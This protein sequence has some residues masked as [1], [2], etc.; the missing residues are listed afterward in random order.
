MRLELSVFHL[1]Q[2]DPHFRYLQPPLHLPWSPSTNATTTLGKIHQY[3]AAYNTTTPTIMSHPLERPDPIAHMLM[4]MKKRVAD[5]NYVPPPLPSVDDSPPRPCSPAWSIG[6]YPSTI[7]TPP[8]SESAC[9]DT[10]FRHPYSAAGS[11]DGKT[12]TNTPPPSSPVGWDD[13]GNSSRTYGL[14][15]GLETLGIE[16]PDWMKDEH[17]SATINIKDG[18]LFDLPDCSAE[19]AMER[20]CAEE[21]RNEDCRLWC[22]KGKC[23]YGR[24]CYYKHDPEKKKKGPRVMNVLWGGI[25][26]NEMRNTKKDEDFWSDDGDQ[27]AKDGWTENEARGKRNRGRGRGRGR[28]QNRGGTRMGGPGWGGQTGTAKGL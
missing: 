13:A 16:V 11:T 17:G 3:L 22:T 1:H 5:P 7:P 8:R 28:G 23:T 18:L 9:S 19:K 15:S 27:G 10:S 2:R 20:A 21:D 4:V 12:N 6:S 25:G 26:M 14:P 24:N